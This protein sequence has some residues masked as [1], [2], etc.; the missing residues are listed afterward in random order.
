MTDAKKILILF[1]ALFGITF[2]AMLLSF[3]P[4]DSI[5][6]TNL[7][8]IEGNDLP[9]LK[10]DSPTYGSDK[11]EILIYH[12]GD[13]S[14]QASA[15]ISESLKKIADE[16]SNITIVWKDFP[17]S[18]LDPESVNAAVAARCAQDRDAFWEYH[19]YL[20]KYSNALDQELYK[21]IGSELEFWQWSFNRC[22]AKESTMDLVEQDLEEAQDISIT[23]APTIFINGQEYIGSLTESELRAII[24]SVLLEL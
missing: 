19:D 11:P 17:N 18:S 20:F 21:E 12:F 16:N 5:S 15:S 14:S 10:K 2:F 23:A 22:L 13:F 3:I 8:E 9:T 6:F 7:P 4:G 24:N 1:S